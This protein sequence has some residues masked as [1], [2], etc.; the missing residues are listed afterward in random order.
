MLSE[1]ARRFA[2]LP[3]TA[4]LLLIISAVLLPIGI[5]LVWAAGQ[6]IRDAN[7][8]LHT[9]AEEQAKLAASAVES[10]VARN[11]LA[12]RIAANGQIADNP[13]ACGT[14]RGSLSV[15]PG[16]GRQFELESPDG[17]PVC[18]VGTVPDT[19]E[20]PLVAPG[21]IALK[22]DQDDDALVFRVGVNGGMA[23]GSL[24]DAEIQNAVRDT[25]AN[26]RSMVLR[27]AG[28]E[29]EIVTPSTLRPV[30]GKLSNTI[31][32][33]ASG[34][35]Q[36]TIGT[37]V[38]M[39]TT[40]DRL[41]LLLPFLMWLIAALLTWV[42]VSRLL[43]RPLRRLQQAV[44]SYQPGD[45][46][47]ELPRKLG[48]AT[49]IQDLRDA[50]G[51]TINNVEES[52]RGLTGALEGQRRLVREV[53]HRVKNNLQ[54]VASLINIHGRSAESPH[55]RAAYGS[56]S[57]RVGALAIVHRNHFAEMEENRGISLRPLVSELAAE[58]RATA[59]EEARGLRID[60]DLEG[61][62]TTQ[63][64]AVSVAFLI[65]EIVE[66]AMLRTPE[67]P[68]EISLRRTSELTARLTLNSKVLN[69]DEEGDREK[70]QFERIISG[71]AKQLRSSLDRKLGRYSV[72]LPV[73]PA[74]DL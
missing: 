27:E 43:I 68:V 3:T 29:L 26:V 69:P 51:R 57:R 44:V 59:P 52:E 64:V 45:S 22:I 40:G 6:G 10:L 39:I 21:N 55:A 8:V 58:L 4:K 12:L 38:P 72:E 30:K 11:A 20:M 17:T 73:F 50:F 53:H 28:R 33:V 31:I 7:Q 9:Q 18:E 65:T 56:I 61:A 63:D 60:L 36:A 1:A 14:V 5:A 41:L 32:P 2:A 16:V 47:F 70:V 35:I 62:N 15:T 24:S 23:T 66:F 54:V 25:G 19:K 13:D 34:R 48:P 67:D 42:L 46:D 37:T 71:L 49:E 74:R